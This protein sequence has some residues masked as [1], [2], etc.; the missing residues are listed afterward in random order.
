VAALEEQGLGGVDDRAT[1]QT[2]PSLCHHKLRLAL[3]Y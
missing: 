3:S 1:S 2:G